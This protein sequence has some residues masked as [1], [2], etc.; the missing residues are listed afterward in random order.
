MVAPQTP[1]T[2]DSLNSGI[3]ASTALQETL[4]TGRLAA[5]ILEPGSGAATPRPEITGNDMRDLIYF[6]RYNTSGRL[7][8]QREPPE[9]PGPASGG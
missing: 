7:D 2:F 6:I 9:I 1:N 8:R 4:A 3:F 5:Y